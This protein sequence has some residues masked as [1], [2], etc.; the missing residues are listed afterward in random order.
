MS[1][2][3]EKILAATLIAVPVKPLLSVAETAD[4]V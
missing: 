1:R 4:T 2:P 3:F